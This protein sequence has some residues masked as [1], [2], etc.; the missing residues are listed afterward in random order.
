MS[1]WSGHILISWK[2]KGQ[3]KVLYWAM[4]QVTAGYQEEILLNNFYGIL[5]YSYFSFSSSLMCQSK[6]AVFG[7]AFHRD[8]DKWELEVFMVEGIGVMVELS[9]SR[10]G[11]IRLGIFRQPKRNRKFGKLNFCKKLSREK[12]DD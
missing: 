12:M 8:T 7:N 10:F 5:D 3:V 4:G 11:L 6:T 9:N 2:Y 1:N